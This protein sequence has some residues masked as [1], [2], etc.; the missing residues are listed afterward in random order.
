MVLE[1]IKKENDIK[2]LSEEE[3]QILPSVIID[4]LIDKISV[5]G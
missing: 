2:E 5:T 4:F 1:K 3:L